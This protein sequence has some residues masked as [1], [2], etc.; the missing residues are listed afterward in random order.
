VHGYLEFLVTPLL[1][2]GHKKEKT[3]GGS[4]TKEGDL[5]AVLGSI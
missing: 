5:G 1:M 2:F 3:E 4:G